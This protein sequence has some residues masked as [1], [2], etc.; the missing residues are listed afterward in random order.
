MGN[1]FFQKKIRQMR[2]E[3]GLT[4]EQLAQEVGVTKSR[5]NMWENN[6]AVP[7][8]DALFRLSE[9]FKV[10]TDDLLGNI[11]S[12]GDSTLMLSI[13][14]NLKKLNAVQLEKANTALKLLFTELWE[15]DEGEENHGDL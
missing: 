8:Q 1:S 10:S 3:R 11:A 12:E 2:E 6:G 15:D 4:M 13:R 7:R 14:R 9:F 5:V